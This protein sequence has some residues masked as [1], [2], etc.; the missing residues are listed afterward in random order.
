M[1]ERSE[2]EIEEE[3]ALLQ[4]PRNIRRRSGSD[5]SS[6][7]PRVQRRRVRGDD[8]PVSDDS[9]IEYLPDR[10]DPSGQPLE[11]KNTTVGGFTR[12]GS[13]E[14][15]PRNDNDWH[16]R[17][18]WRSLGEPDPAL[19]SDIAQTLGGL[20]QPG[21]SLMNIFGHVLRDI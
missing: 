15:L 7:R 16:V 6:N 1:G 9:E 20:L 5:V 18:A 17:G 10:F 2:E 19:V 14:Y 11:T 21:G 4:R 12:Q 8:S 3:L 13:F